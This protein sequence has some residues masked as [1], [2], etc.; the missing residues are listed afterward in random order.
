[1]LCVCFVDFYGPWAHSAREKA[2]GLHQAGLT[3]GSPPWCVKT[4]SVEI[5]AMAQESCAS[6]G[7]TTPV[8]RITVLEMGVGA[9]Q[10]NDHTTQSIQ[11]DRKLYFRR[12]CSCA[13]GV[14]SP[15]LVGQEFSLFTVE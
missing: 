14:L 10:E 6:D 13:T 15:I 9:S 2:P 11:Q 7:Q 4:V 8:T 1:M 12:L 5:V 3:F